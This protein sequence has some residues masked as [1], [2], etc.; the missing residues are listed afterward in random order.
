MIGRNVLP[1]SPVEERLRLSSLFLSLRR[2]PREAIHCLHNI[3]VDRCIGDVAEKR[4][5]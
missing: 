5:N 2:W 1:L 4:A 3:T